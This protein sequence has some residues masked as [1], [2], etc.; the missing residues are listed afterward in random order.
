MTEGSRESIS[1]KR[2]AR[3][4][5]ISNFRK[6]PTFPPF[7]SHESFDFP[8]TDGVWV[9]AGGKLASGSSAIARAFARQGE[10]EKASWS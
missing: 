5:S 4:S 9:K 2:G 7:E 1:R 3:I 8:T 6:S 10:K